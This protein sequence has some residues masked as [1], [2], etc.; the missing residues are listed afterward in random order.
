MKKVLQISK[1]YYPFIGG[2]EQVARDIAKALSQMDSVEQKIICFNKDA[3]DG[4]YHCRGKETVHDSVDGVEVIRCGYQ[5]EIS[6]Q[7]LSMT[8]PAELKKLMDDFQPDVVILHYPN[9][10]VTH[11]LLQYSKRSFRLLVYWHL[12]ITRQKILGK[13]FHGQ[14]LALIQR[15]DLILGATR[16]HVDES[17]YT[18]CFGNKR[19]ILPYCIDEKKLV[20]TEEEEKRT[21]KLREK[22][23]GK[24]LGFFIGRHVPY[25]GLKH[26]V[27][28]SRLLPPGSKLHFLIAGQG[29]L[30]DELKKQAQGDEKIEFLGKIDDSERR[31]CLQA[32]DIFCFPSVT[33]NEGFG[34]ALAESMYFGKP[35]VTFTIPG[36]GVNFVNLNGVTGI[37][38]PNRNS[39]AYAEALQKLAD[40]PALRAEYGKNA[41]QRALENFTTEQFQRRIR[42][43]L[44]E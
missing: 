23:A 1:Y 35:A 3:D 39:K 13:L 44:Q 21:R 42:E 30:T 34:L 9:P 25:K 18:P 2:T 43:L 8:Y 31:V 27:E 36:S 40:N 32:C 37:E 5:M 7:A 6:S 41:R 16:M 33:R 28:A 20:M 4:A 26:L 24:I 15:A 17:A 22:Y 12:D 29:P 14:N 38:C 10:F 11:Y 19:Y